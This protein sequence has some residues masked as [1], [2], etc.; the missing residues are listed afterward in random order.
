MFPLT[1]PTLFQT[2]DCYFLSVKMQNKKVKHRPSTKYWYFHTITGLTL[3][4]SGEKNRKI[5]KSFSYLLTKLFFS[6]LVETQLFFSCLRIDPFSEG[7]QNN[8]D[9]VASAESVH[10]PLVK[11]FFNHYHLL[12]IF[13]RQQIEIFFF[14]FFSENRLCHFIQIV[15]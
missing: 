5:K 15:S 7:K 1:R 6:M 14:F 8:F 13:S 4:F 3:F 12:H 11:L 9:R 2:P 10:F